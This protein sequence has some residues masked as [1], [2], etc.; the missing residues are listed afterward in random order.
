MNTQKYLSH[1]PQKSRGLIKLIKIGGACFTLITLLCGSLAVHIGAENS[2]QVGGKRVAV[3][4]L[5]SNNERG[6]TTKVY[7]IYGHTQDKVNSEKESTQLEVLQLEYT[8]PARRRAKFTD[9]KLSTIKDVS[10]LTTIDQFAEVFIQSKDYKALAQIVNDP[11]L[12][13]VEKAAVMSVPPPAPVTSARFSAK[14][15][16]ETIVRNGYTDTNGKKW[17]GKGVYVAIIDTGIDFTHPDFIT[18]D[19]YGNSTSR[20]DYFWDTT[21][22]FCAGRGVMP[23]YSYPNKTPIGTLFQQHHFTEELQAIQKGEPRTIPSTDEAGHGTTCASIAAGN[24]NADWRQGG[25]KRTEVQGT[26][27]EVHII[28]IRVGK[29]R[30]SLKN[31]YLLN[32]ICEWLDQ[33]VGD[34]PLVIS[35]SFGSNYGS[36]DGQTINER[37]LNARFGYGDRK[38]R[39]MVVSAGNMSR[40]SIH[41]EATFGNVNDAAIVSWEAKE[42][43]TINIFFDTSVARQL[44]IVSMDSAKIGHEQLSWELN[45]ITNQVQATLSVKEG[46]GQIKLFN[47]SGV[48]TEAH[49][50]FNSPRLGAFQHGVDNAYLV[51]APGSAADAITVGSSAWNDSF[52]MTGN[53]VTFPSTC[54]NDDGDWMLL[55]IGGLSCYSSPGPT[56]D[57]RNKPD[58]VAPGEWYSASHSANAKSDVVDTTG[59]YELMNGTSAATAYTAGIIALLLE[60]DPSLTTKRIKQLFENELTKSNLKPRSNN[61]PNAI[62]GNGKLDMPSVGRLFES[63]NDSK[64]TN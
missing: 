41:A 37:E 11:N 56:R 15:I 40:K 28:G 10:V 52:H 51:T 29:D 8:N 44:K 13:R 64:A 32:V 9:A 14:G 21:L 47:T 62:W 3:I 4:S 43:T 63:L 31:A 7:E 35:A 2:D 49:L 46:K 50:Y 18:Y 45:R 60:K 17:T 24:G 22:D 38:G 30:S 33:I 20:L 26:A 6:L 19:E 23:P 55:E 16:P 53:F 27:P 58:V 61:F 54:R 1:R 36:H 5:D 42:D 34:H 57:N 59:K 25:L 39:V 48:Q 12:V